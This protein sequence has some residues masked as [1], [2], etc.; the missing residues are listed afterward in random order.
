LNE[1][2]LWL[3]TKRNL[4]RDYRFR[5]GNENEETIETMDKGLIRITEIS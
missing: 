1:L 4:L 2:E 5:I 3:E